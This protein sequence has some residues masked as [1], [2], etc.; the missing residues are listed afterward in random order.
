MFTLKTGFRIMLLSMNKK[1]FSLIELLVVVAIIAMLISM[2]TPSLRKIK[3]HARFLVCRSKISQL[4]ISLSVYNSGNYT[5]PFGFDDAANSGCAPDDGYLGNISRDKM[6]WWWINYIDADTAKNSIDWC[7]SRTIAEQADRGNILCG[8]YGVNRAICKDSPGITG[9]TGDEFAG[10]PLSLSQIRTPSHT[11]L[12]ADSGYSLISWKA[13]T[14][15]VSSRFD[16]PAREE[17]FYI[18]GMKINKNR[19]LNTGK[20]PLAVTGRHPRSQINIAYSDGHVS[21]VEAD[22]L[23]VNNPANINNP[24]QAK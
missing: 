21:G 22:D 13:A 11:L 15:S 12:L 5:F 17:Y 6:G 23:I 24:W 2:I 8:N 1:G 16:N 3:D 7:P 10:K 18:P 20:T 4:S 14:N 19:P 9:I